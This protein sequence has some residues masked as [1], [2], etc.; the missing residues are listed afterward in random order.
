VSKT[1][2]S[3]LRK[4]RFRVQGRQRIGAGRNQERAEP[5]PDA[6]TEEI[7]DKIEAQLAPTPAMTQPAQARIIEQAGGICVIEVTCSC[8]QVVHLQCFVDPSAQTPSP[9]GPG[10]QE[11]AT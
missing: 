7:A 1:A 11:N 10:Q 6:R 2:D 4:G 5:T 3:I 9:Q 8:G